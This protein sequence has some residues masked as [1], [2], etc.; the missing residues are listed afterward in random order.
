MGR[1]IHDGEEA[2][3]CR[4]EGRGALESMIVEEEETE[5][6]PKVRKTDMDLKAIG[7]QMET[8]K[9]E[10]MAQMDKGQGKAVQ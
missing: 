7:A 9:E 2:E 8:R 10:L 5:Y 3:A 4:E 6:F 1:E